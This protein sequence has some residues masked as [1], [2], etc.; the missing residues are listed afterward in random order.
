[1][2]LEE[3]SNYS[4]LLKEPGLAELGPPEVAE[5]TSYS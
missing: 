4:K 3:H 2:N 5:V 1:M